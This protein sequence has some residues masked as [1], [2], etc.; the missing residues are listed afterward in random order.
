MKKSI[1]VGAATV[2]VLSVFVGCGAAAPA[3]PKSLDAPSSPAGDAQPEGATADEAASGEVATPAAGR[4]A[5]GPSGKEP[6]EEKLR[7]SKSLDEPF[8]KIE[9]VTK[10]IGAPF[11]TGKATR[12]AWW[13]EKRPLGK[14]FSCETIDLIR[15]PSGRVVLDV[16]VYTSDDCKKVPVT[17][18]DVV[19]ALATLSG[20]PAPADPI[21]EHMAE[22]VRT[23]SFDETSALFEKKLGKPRAA[24]EPDLAAWRYLD[25]AGE[26]R[27]LVVTSHLGSGAGQ[28]IWGLPCD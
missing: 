15:A 10:E 16:S 14:T 20:E 7:G 21:L 17:K 3:A 4:P 22:N 1:A 26:C 12:R 9:E 5:K 2:A 27:V 25:D 8:P 13:F 28:A 6:S 24:G 18:A 23:K 19:K 11:A